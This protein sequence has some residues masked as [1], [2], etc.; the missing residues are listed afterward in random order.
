M[1]VKMPRKPGL[2]LTGMPQHVI[3][4]GNNREPCFYSPDDYHRYLEDLKEA[5][6]KN[7]CTVIIL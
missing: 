6:D 5:T 2:N 4:R 7:K 1:E 3:Q